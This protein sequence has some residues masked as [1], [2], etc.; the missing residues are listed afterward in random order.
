M[1]IFRKMTVL[2][3]HS[4][5]HVFCCLF[6]CFLDDTYFLSLACSFGCIHYPLLSVFM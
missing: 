3:A 5:A 1:Y 6:V 4:N 2:T